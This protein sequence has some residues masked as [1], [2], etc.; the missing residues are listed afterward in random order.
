MGV[1]L[2]GC[3]LMDL[4]HRADILY[5]MTMKSLLSNGGYNMYKGNNS[6]TPIWHSEINIKDCYWR[7]GAMSKMKTVL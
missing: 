3:A 5:F 2:V 1:N 4:Y 7:Q 6:L